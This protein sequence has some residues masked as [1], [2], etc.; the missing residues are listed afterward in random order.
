M[1]VINLN[2]GYITLRTEKAEA[3]VEDLIRSGTLFE[4]VSNL[5]E[6]DANKDKSQTKLL[7][8]ILQHLQSSSSTGGNGDFTPISPSYNEASALPPV[9]KRDVVVETVSKGAKKSKRDL[10]K[11]LIGSQG[12]E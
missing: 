3:L 11:G 6:E 2:N 5:I 10:L 8:N 9:T 4:Y 7:E 12:G 1:R